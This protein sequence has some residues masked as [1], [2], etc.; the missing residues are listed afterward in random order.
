MAKL[1]DAQLI[2]LF[3][4]L[5]STGYN[6]EKEK[7]ERRPSGKISTEELLG[8]YDKRAE[9]R[10]AQDIQNI[11]ES[12]GIKFRIKDGRAVLEIGDA[13]K[14]KLSD[15]LERANLTQDTE[16]FLKNFSNAAHRSGVAKEAAVIQY[17]IDADSH[18]V[19]NG[20]I[21]AGGNYLL[22]VDE[23]TGK[24]R[25][26]DP[27]QAQKELL[28]ALE[29]MGIELT[30]V[31]LLPIDGRG[32]VVI[33]FKSKEDEAYARSLL[34]KAGY[35]ESEQP[36]QELLK[37]LKSAYLKLD[38]MIDKSE[39]ITEESLQKRVPHRDDLNPIVQIDGREHDCRR[40]QGIRELHVVKNGGKIL[41]D[42]AQQ[43][44]YDPETNAYVIITSQSRKDLSET[45]NP[46]QAIY[47]VTFE[48]G[49]DPSTVKIAY[50]DRNE[51]EYDVSLEQVKE[52]ILKVSGRDGANNGYPVAYSV[53]PFSDDAQAWLNKTRKEHALR[54]KGNAPYHPI[55]A[56]H[57]QSHI[58]NLEF[59]VNKVTERF[60]MYDEQKPVS[61]VPLRKNVVRV[62]YRSFAGNP[63]DYTVEYADE[64]DRNVNEVTG[65]SISDYRSFVKNRDG[66][67]VGMY[68]FR[69]DEDRKTYRVIS[70]RVQ[71][72]NEEGSTQALDRDGNP[73]KDPKGNPI[74]F[75]K[76]PRIVGPKPNAELFFG[77]LER[78]TSNNYWLQVF[79]AVGDNVKDK[80][81]PKSARW[82][83][84]EFANHVNMQSGVV[85]QEARRPKKTGKDKIED[86]FIVDSEGNVAKWAEKTWTG[87]RGNA[88]S[89][90]N[91]AHAWGHMGHPILTDTGVLGDK[92]FPADAPQD[93]LRELARQKAAWKRIDQPNKAAGQVVGD[94]IIDVGEMRKGLASSDGPRL[95]D[96]LNAVNWK[97][98]S[99]LDPDIDGV[100]RRDVSKLVGRDITPKALGLWIAS[101]NPFK[102]KSGAAVPKTRMELRSRPAEAFSDVRT[103]DVEPKKKVA[104]QAPKQNP[105]MSMQRARDILVKMD[106]NRD[107]EV[108]GKEV[109]DAREKAPNMVR[110]LAE[111]MDTDGNKEVSF[112]EYDAVSKRGSA[113]NAAFNELS[114]SLQAPVTPA[115][116]PV[117]KKKRSLD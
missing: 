4:S 10:V 30:P 92:S 98:E 73:I 28:Y 103:E 108:D 83:Q 9:E 113:I 102:S 89:S 58:S 32:E 52:H 110:A 81:E 62:L 24:L 20:N 78:A 7:I 96:A 26:S 80:N 68:E 47:F 37:N 91:Q 55:I 22:G 65:K 104:D 59:D 101:M 27:K 39:M 114:K 66:E 88:G 56:P 117:D 74:T 41:L 115:A 86:R 64:I 51:R 79:A 54:E 53:G 3:K 6:T 69:F 72:F 8:E 82:K 13:T 111:F 19:A 67:Y 31:G 70:N 40:C 29:V 84:D 94:G 60:A 100:S 21:V 46:K 77:R 57:H 48:K 2:K 12:V 36:M 14:D 116:Q 43:I 5:D 107:G 35:R 105:E 95:R 93:E 76:D 34:D 18:H 23:L 44:H 42:R 99:F 71:G 112:T 75:V 109:K 15:L 97:G 1:S 16:Q 50:T 87:I 106:K 33:K 11:A 90:F 38:G 25:K 85:E 61:E 17:L 45:R 63:T 49:V